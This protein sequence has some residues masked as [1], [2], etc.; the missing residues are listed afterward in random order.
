MKGKILWQKYP[1][2]INKYDETQKMVQ[3]KNTHK[4]FILS[5]TTEKSMHKECSI[6]CHYI[7]IS[8][9]PPKSLCDLNEI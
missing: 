7:L 5:N 6:H 4:F 3:L 2:Y 9:T 1:K 8:C